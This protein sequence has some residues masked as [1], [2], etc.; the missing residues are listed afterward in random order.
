MDH[1]DWSPHT[2]AMEAHAPRACELQQE[3]PTEREAQALAVKK[4]NAY[5]PQLEKAQTPR[6]TK[7]KSFNNQF[8]K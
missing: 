7:N 1:N 3:K 5:K 6:T 2:A 8:F 4:S